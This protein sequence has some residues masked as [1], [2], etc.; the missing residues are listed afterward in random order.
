[1]PE[2][3]TSQGKAD[4]PPDRE[5]PPELRQILDFHRLWLDTRGKE[6]SRAILP[7][8][9]F[10]GLKLSGENLERADLA[11]AE[12][13]GA[14]L[15]EANLKQAQLQGAIFSQAILTGADFRDA[16]LERADLGDSKGL[17]LLLLA[18]AN[19]AGC[20]LPDDQAKFA[21]LDYVKDASSIT[22][23]LF[24]AMLITCVYTGITVFTTSDVALLTNTGTTKLPLL[25]VDISVASFYFAAPLLLLAIYIYFHL[26][27]QHLW[28]SLANLPAIFPDGQ[29]LDQKVYPWLFNW[30]PSAYFIRLQELKNRRV[31]MAHLQ[32]YLAAFFAWFFLPLT[33][34]LLGGRYLY[35]R[36]LYV[37][38]YHLLIVAAAVW[39]GLRFS[40]YAGT[41]LR[42]ENGKKSGRVLGNAV[43]TC[44]VLLLMYALA[45]GFIYGVPARLEPDL[46]PEIGW[47]KHRTL[48]PEVLD[49]LRLR[50]VV[51]FEEK[52]VSTRSAP[53]EGRKGE[54]DADRESP[55]ARG[56]PLKGRNLWYAGAKG[57]YMARADLRR[58]NLE[59]GAYLL[60]VDL[61]EAKLGEAGYPW[62]AAELPK[63]LLVKADL[64]KACLYRANLHR[65]IL[66]GANL[67]GCELEAAVLAEA[68]LRYAN[69]RGAKLK[70]T[71][72]RAA[73][74]QGADFT[75]A[76]DLEARQIKE[77]NVW[78]LARYDDKLLKELGLPPDH[79]KLVETL[80]FVK[81]NLE[82][83][84]FRGADVSRFDFTESSLQGADLRKANL[85][86]SI[87]QKANLSQ[88][89]LRQ[90]YL[91]LA[92]LKEAELTEAVLDGANL[93]LAD[94]Q[95]AKGLKEGQV[96][97]GR[98]WSLAFYDAE[99][100]RRLNLPPDHNTR[101]WTQ[102]LSGYDLQGAALRRCIPG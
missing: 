49:S 88:A 55:L 67:T 76:K 20:R 71:I 23:N 16:D 31:F 5:I 24:M 3:D 27:L 37:T 19:L 40:Y 41:T 39:F 91:Y 6:G 57:A 1:M 53:G 2:N 85:K 84:N 74:L 86:R 70:G 34:V 10:Q 43:W 12:F 78:I 8:Y 4:S 79:N 72:L 93:L 36:N 62:L 26:N 21:G 95:G 30:L 101:V 50:I 87:L 47:F 73:N 61:R 13:Q 81:L 89:Q 80:K 18:R 63:A 25:G 66:E 33:L 102:Q 28:E 60:G 83:A 22:S 69:L 92:N 44:L 77:A 17:S 42:G 54:K 15:R 58:A 14:D 94:F 90:S 48:V 45:D 52:D 99:M 100:I 65:A 35:V 97:S 32:K 98:N 7:H 46:R 11:G 56:A 64:S 96:K 75:G 82:R 29:Q 51:N 9:S 68:N 59:E 38:H